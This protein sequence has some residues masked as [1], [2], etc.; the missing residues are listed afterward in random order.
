MPERIVVSAK[1]A[2]LEWERIKIEGRGWPIIVGDD[3]RMNQVI[4]LVDLTSS[5]KTEIL[6]RA[7]AIDFPADLDAQ[8]T[9]TWSK[10]AKKIKAKLAKPD[11][12]LTGLMNFS[13]DRGVYEMTPEEVRTDLLRQLNE[14]PF[15]FGEWPDEPPY[16]HDALPI[17][18]RERNLL[19]E[20]NIL[21]IPVST[22]PEALAYFNYTAGSGPEPEY[23][24]AALKRWYADVGAEL[25]ALTRDSVTLRVASRPQTKEEALRLA[26]E[27][28]LYCSDDERPLA[29]IAHEIMHT[30]EWF[31]WWD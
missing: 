15:P 23:H 3:K 18:D 31:F 14:G 25:V 28:V 30:D 12:E 24:V 4:S 22:G 2:L 26:K 29:H 9:A 13:E 17:Y 6:T 10:A 19:P 27:R 16:P 1:N 5:G 21:R 20:I 11:E 7:E 8:R